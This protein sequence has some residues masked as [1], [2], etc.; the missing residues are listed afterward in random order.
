MP[1]IYT[2]SIVE[3]EPRTGIE[4][5]QELIQTTFAKR[6][7]TI[8]QFHDTIYIPKYNIAHIKFNF[9]IDSYTSLNQHLYM[10]R[11][12]YRL[13]KYADEE[14]AYNRQDK[15][16]RGEFNPTIEPFEMVYSTSP[17]KCWEVKLVNSY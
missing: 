8:T 5:L 15:H 12:M 1:T 9:Y 17:R 3:I 13:Q 7:I 4:G 11:M 6:G 16:T 14:A 10:E 2:A